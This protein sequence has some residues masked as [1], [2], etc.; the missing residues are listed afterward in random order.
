[1]SETNSNTKPVYE[2]QVCTQ[3]RYGPNPVSCG[4]KASQQLIGGLQQTLAAEY[5]HIAVVPVPCMLL[6]EHGPNVRLA[7][8]GKH[9]LMNADV[10]HQ[11]SPE[12]FPVMLQEIKNKLK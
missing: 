5:L 6:C 8:A 1:M 10:W 12:K 9:M 2:L 3:M 7:Q 4:N 11:V